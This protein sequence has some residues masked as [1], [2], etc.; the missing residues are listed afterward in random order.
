MPTQP[1]MKLT[2]H[3]LDALSETF[4]DSLRLLAFDGQSMRFEFCIVRQ[5]EPK[6]PNPLT[7]RQVPVCRLVMSL[8]M[9]ID[10]MNKVKAV[11]DQLTAAGILTVTQTP[12]ASGIKH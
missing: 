2:Y 10:L 12:T 11:L 4:T 7:G 6:P 5:D 1:Q 3:D 9:A 8:P